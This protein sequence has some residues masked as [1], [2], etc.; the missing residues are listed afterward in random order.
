[1]ELL[2]SPKSTYLLEAGLDVLHEQ[3]IEWLNEIAFWRDETAFFYSLVAKKTLEAV[4]VKA[5]SYIEKTE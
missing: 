1:M 2:T 5:K 3:S 4:P